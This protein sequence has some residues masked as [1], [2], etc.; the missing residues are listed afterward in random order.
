MVHS[1]NAISTEQ[2]KALD[3]ALRRDTI[4]MYL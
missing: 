3:P 2:V 4:R 1:P